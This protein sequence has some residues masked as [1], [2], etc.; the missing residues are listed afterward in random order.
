VGDCHKSVG[1]QL[2]KVSRELTGVI[3]EVQEAPRRKDL[4]RPDLAHQTACS[5]ITWPLNEREDA[6]P[7]VRWDIGTIN[8]HFGVQKKIVI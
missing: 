1:R 5:T 8:L 3:R 6:V 7:G 2:R 4:L